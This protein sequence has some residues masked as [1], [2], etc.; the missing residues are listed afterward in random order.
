MS[1]PKRHI[2]K[3]FTISPPNSLATWILNFAACKDAHYH[4]VS[5]KTVIMISGKIFP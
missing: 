2:V 4:H 3:I 1:K 5:T